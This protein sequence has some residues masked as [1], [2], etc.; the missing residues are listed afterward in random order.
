MSNATRTGS[1]H[2]EN[3]GTTDNHFALSVESQAQLADAERTAVS[4]E[5]G[6]ILN[7]YRL[8][9][10]A[11]PHDARWDQAPSLGT[12]IVAARTAG[13][14]RIVAAG[15]EL[16]FQEVDALPAE[17]VSTRNASAFRD[18]KAYTVIEVEHGREGLQRGVIDG[19]VPVDTIR[20]TQV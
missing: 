5:A 11:P 10:A 15:G 1:I 19:E 6:E 17:D 2:S 13:D 20:P 4:T 3:T 9:P 18:E 14:A 16:D 8:E 7:I 12:V